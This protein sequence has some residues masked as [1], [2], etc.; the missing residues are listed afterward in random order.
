MAHRAVTLVVMIVL[1]L[2]LVSAMT[3]SGIAQWSGR[4]LVALLVVLLLAAV[5][6]VAFSWRRY[7]GGRQS[8]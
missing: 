4:S 7:F 6:G 8:R 1:A 2:L 3:A 5:G